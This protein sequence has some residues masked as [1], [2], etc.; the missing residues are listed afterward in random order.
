MQADLMMGSPLAAENQMSVAITVS[1]KQSILQL[2]LTSQ[3]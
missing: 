1:M 3:P 2:S